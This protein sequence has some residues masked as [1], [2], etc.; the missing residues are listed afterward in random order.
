MTMTNENNPAITGRP[1]RRGD[2]TKRIRIT[3]G[4]VAGKSPRLVGEV[5]DLPADEAQDL[6]A[7]KKAEAAP[8][9][10]VGLPAEPKGK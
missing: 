1:S 2:E 7:I 3:R 9:E 5:L 6:I 4:C 8:G 10:K